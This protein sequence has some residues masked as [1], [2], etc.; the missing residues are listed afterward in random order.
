MKHL[1][2]FNESREEL[3]LQREE[4]HDFCET[5]LAYLLDEGFELNVREH[6]ARDSWP[7]VGNRDYPEFGYQTDYFRV[8][9]YKSD[10]SL[11][12]WEEISDRF[13]PFVKYLIDNYNLLK[14]DPRATVTSIQKSRFNL[15]FTTGHNIKFQSKELLDNSSSLEG[16]ELRSISFVVGL[17]K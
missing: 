6:S 10:D 1:K 4:L 3:T 12:L 8:S 2:R 13:I 16:K 11:F 7:S 17:P 14:I 9:F 5:Y 15:E